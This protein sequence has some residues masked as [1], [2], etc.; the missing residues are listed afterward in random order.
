MA[1]QTDYKFVFEDGATASLQAKGKG[2][3]R[4][5]LSVMCQ[6]RIGQTAQGSDESGAIF[7]AKVIKMEQADG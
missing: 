7:K 6:D 5:I 1:G 2:Q 4:T 3:A